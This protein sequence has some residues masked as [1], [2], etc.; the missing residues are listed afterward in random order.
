MS[1]CRDDITH[2][3]ILSHPVG[4]VPVSFFHNDGT[5]RK[6]TKSDFAKKLELKAEKRV[7]L[8]NTIVG[9]TV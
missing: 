1:K 6:T 3:T 8:P 2:E 4:S 5:M 9:R 7:V